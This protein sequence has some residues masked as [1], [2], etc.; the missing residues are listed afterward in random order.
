M[1]TLPLSFPGAQGV[2]LAARLELPERPPRAFA[3]FAHCFTCGKNLK[4]AHT[5]SRALAEAGIAVLRFDFTGLGESEGDF[6]ATTFASNVASR[7]SRAIRRGNAAPRS[8]STARVL[9]AH[10]QPP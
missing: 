4:A 8:R 5:I 10:R 9:N 2:A 7:Q 3:L 6:A 1:P